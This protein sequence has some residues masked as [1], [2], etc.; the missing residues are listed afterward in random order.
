MS[1]PMLSP[2]ICSRCDDCASVRVRAFIRPLHAVLSKDKS[3]QFSLGPYLKSLNGDFRDIEID[4]TILDTIVN[5]SRKYK[6]DNLAVF[7]FSEIG[8][9]ITSQ[10]NRYKHTSGS[11]RIRP[12]SCS[13]HLALTATERP[14]CACILTQTDT[15]FF[16]EYP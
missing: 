9:H 10:S 12:T 1:G 15:P 11:L 3:S 6:F 5:W 14:R 13:R 2:S 7:A 8:F 16:P 4:D